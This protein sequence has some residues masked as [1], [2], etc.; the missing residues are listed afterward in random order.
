MKKL[1]LLSAALVVMLFAS[2]SKSGDKE[3]AIPTSISLGHSYSDTSAERIEGVP[4]F[5]KEKIAFMKQYRSSNVP[6]DVW[7]CSLNGKTVYQFSGI[8]VDDF[9]SLYDS[10]G[11]FICY[12]S[13]GFTGKGDGKFPD[14]YKQATDWKLLWS[15]K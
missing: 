7:Q 15:S 2:C 1:L 4:A 6:V 11:V 9:Y 3:V 5:V 8:H 14:F 10:E 13:G 12:P